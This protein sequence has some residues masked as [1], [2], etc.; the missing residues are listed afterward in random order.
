LLL[1]GLTI[2]SLEVAGYSTRNG[3]CLRPVA[4]IPVDPFS[5]Q[6]KFLCDSKGFA[7][8]CRPEHIRL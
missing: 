7:I 2:D 8:L 4:S 3:S 6:S 1:D 5:I